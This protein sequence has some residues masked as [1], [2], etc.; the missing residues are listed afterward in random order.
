LQSPY[1]TDDDWVFASPHSGGKLP[2]WPGSLYKAHLEPAAKEIGIKGSA[3]V[4][5]H[6]GTRTRRFSRNGEDVKVVQDMTRRSS[7]FHRDQNWRAATQK[8]LVEHTEFW[9]GMSALECRQL[10]PQ[11]KILQEQILLVAKGRGYSR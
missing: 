11:S 1:P 10:L 2:Y 8:E 3:S 9:F 6:S 4:G 5:I 7:C